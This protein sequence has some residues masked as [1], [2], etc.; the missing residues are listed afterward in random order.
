MFTRLNSVLLVS[1]ESEIRGV[2]T[3]ALPVCC[4]YGL[5]LSLGRN[6][7]ARIYRLICLQMIFQFQ[8]CP[9]MTQDD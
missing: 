6:E 9:P 5:S 4:C 8:L 3:T 7:L 1:E 2:P